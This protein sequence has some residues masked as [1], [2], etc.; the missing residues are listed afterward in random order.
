MHALRQSHYSVGGMDPSTLI[1]NE[2]IHHIVLVHIHASVDI[3]AIFQ[4]LLRVHS[5]IFFRY[6]IKICIKTR[7]V[8]K[9]SI[10]WK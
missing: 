6:N 1:A 7:H 10:I 5:T 4:Q 8:K 3:K 9:D 2:A